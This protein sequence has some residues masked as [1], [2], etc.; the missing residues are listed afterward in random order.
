MRTQKAHIFLI[1]YAVAAGGTASGVVVV[2]IIIL[3]AKISIAL[4][5]CLAKIHRLRACVSYAL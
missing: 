2:V 5:W 4:V 3:V 1:L